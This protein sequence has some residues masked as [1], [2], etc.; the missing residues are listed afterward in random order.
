MQSTS[1]LLEHGSRIVHF[2]GLRGEVGVS[3]ESV[4]V[5]AYSLPVPPTEVTT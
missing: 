3:F 2:K 1:Q 4:G 5:Y